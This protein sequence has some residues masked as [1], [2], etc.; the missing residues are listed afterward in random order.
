MIHPLHGLKKKILDNSD[1]E[2]LITFIKS[3][4]RSMLKRGI[5]AFAD[6][7]EG[8]SEGIKLLNDALFD[9]PIKYV[10]LGRPEFY[11]SIH[12]SSHGEKVERPPYKSPKETMSADFNKT[13]QKILELCDGFGISGANENSDESLK[14]YRKIV[15]EYKEK[16]RR[17]TIVAIHAAESEQTVTL[18]VSA[19]GKSEV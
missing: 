4:A 16:S 5:V 19:T 2:H 17:N 10:A 7:R 11:F 8:G 3:S 13:S 18:S 15:L 1:R 6:F 12:P 14:Q 9:T